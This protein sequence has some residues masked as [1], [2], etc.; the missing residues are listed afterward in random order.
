MSDD[1][2]Y[3]TPS[4]D[5]GAEIWRMV[6]ESVNLDRDSGYAY[7]MVARNFAATSVVAERGEHTI[8]MLTAYRLPQ[9]PRRLFVWQV[10]VRDPHKNSG[11]ASGMLDHLLQR[12]EAAGVR[13]VEATIVPGNTPAENLFKSL[14]NR[15]DCPI[16]ETEAFADEL[17]PDAERKVE[18]LFVVGP[19]PYEKCEIRIRPEGGRYR[20]YSF[21]DGSELPAFEPANPA[22]DDFDDA[23]RA[24]EKVRIDHGA[25]KVV[26]ERE[27]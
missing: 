16:R 12:D 26:V 17:F 10:N 21:W 4:I 2:T 5:D 22:F 14:A 24:A 1:V 20:L 3:R 8:G 23:K 15:L 18:R 11:I 6:D 9:D 25:S 7:F 27:G 13:W 19:I